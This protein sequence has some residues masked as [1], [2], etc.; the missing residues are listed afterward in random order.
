MN[1]I[2]VENFTI[3][4]DV[5]SD[6]AIWTVGSR[7]HHVLTRS[8]SVRLA[9]LHLIINAINLFKIICKVS[10]INAVLI[11]NIIHEDILIAFIYLFI[12]LRGV[13]V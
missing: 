3:G 10:I 9:L 1:G 4:A 11:I 7:S 5:L 8:N 13:H 6:D 2:L 12:Y